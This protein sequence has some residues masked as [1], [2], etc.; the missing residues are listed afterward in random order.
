M[1]DGSPTLLGSY[2]TRNLTQLSYHPPKYNAVN[3]SDRSHKHVALE[4]LRHHIQQ[5]NNHQHGQEGKHNFP[6]RMRDSVRLIIARK[7]LFFRYFIDPRLNCGLLTLLAQLLFLHLC[8]S[9]NAL[10]QLRLIY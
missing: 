3:N 6:S 9:A 4:N 8:R 1:R 2:L 7:T 5:P 10:L